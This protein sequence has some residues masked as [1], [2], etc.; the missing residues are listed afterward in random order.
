MVSFTTLTAVSLIN[1]SVR[2]WKGLKADLN[3]LI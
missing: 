3:P 1:N 2:G